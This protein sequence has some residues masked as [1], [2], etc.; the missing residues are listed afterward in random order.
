A[1]GHTHAPRA[2]GA[3]CTGAPG[4]RKACR[5]SPV[6][7]ML[8]LPQHVSDTTHG[9][10]QTRLAGRLGLG[11]EVSDVHFEDRIVAAEVITPDVLEET[12][13]RQDPPGVAQQVC[14]QVELLGTQRELPVAAPC[15]AGQ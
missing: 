4:P 10:D 2:T 14:Q 3:I 11:T 7:L 9:L 12:G 1:D 15:L 6:P 13:A 5:P 8:V